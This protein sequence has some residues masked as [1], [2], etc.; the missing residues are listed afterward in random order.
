MLT[1]VQLVDL[2]TDEGLVLEPES[3]AKIQYQ[4]AMLEEAFRGWR[5]Y[6]VPTSLARLE[7]GWAG[8]VRLQWNMLRESSQRRRALL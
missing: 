7:V 1:N 2:G 8:S 3:R 5:T 6:F 4:D